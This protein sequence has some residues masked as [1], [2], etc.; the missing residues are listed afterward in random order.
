MAAAN[1]N[2]LIADRQGSII[3]AAN[4]LGSTTGTYTYDPYGVPAAWTTPPFG[5]TGQLALPQAKLW[6]YKARVYDPVAGR[7]LQTDPVGYDD[8]NRAG[9][10]NLDIWLSGV[11]A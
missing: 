2:Y 11:S 5:Y 4:A 1:A 7:F 6:F 10:L 3:A 9:R 8:N